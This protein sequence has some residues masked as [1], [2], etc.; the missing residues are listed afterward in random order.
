[1]LVRTGR[2]K[3]ENKQND[4]MKENE[5]RIKIIKLVVTCRES[6]ERIL[7]YSDLFNCAC[8]CFV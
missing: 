7:Y 6:R 4:K 1:M 5:G 2:E 3:K 8:S